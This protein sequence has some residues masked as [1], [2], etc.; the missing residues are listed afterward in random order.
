MGC[1]EGWQLKPDA[2]RAKYGISVDAALQKLRPHLALK[3]ALKLN[4]GL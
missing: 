4:A 2:L 1:R 3:P